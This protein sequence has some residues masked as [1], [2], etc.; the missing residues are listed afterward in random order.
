MNKAAADK[1]GLV[2]PV[3]G[4]QQRLMSLSVGLVLF[5]PIPFKDTAPA[6]KAMLD[7]YLQFVPR[8]QFRWQNLGGSSA[9]FKALAPRAFATTDAWLTFQRSY[10]RSCAIW[11][12]DGPTVTSVGD[13]L[14]NLWGKDRASRPCDS[15]YLR[16]HF[17]WSV[18]ETDAREGFLT[19][20]HAMLQD[21]PFHSGYLGYMLN[22]STLA[23]VVPYSDAINTAFYAA[24]RR[25]VGLE[26]TKPHLEN[27]E[28]KCFLRPPSWVT[29]VSAPFLEKLG[30]L[31]QLRGELKGTFTF[32][33]LSHGWSIQAGSEP[34][35]GDQNRQQDVAPEQRELARRFAPLYSDKPAYLF[36]DKPHLETVD[37]MRRL[38]K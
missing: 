31:E 16:L 22:V 34:R 7:S 3:G 38:T 27:Y 5:T 33:Q 4:D 11:L 21:V 12:K 2:M 36:A 37:W 6:F 18:A 23:T 8:T 25:Y 19:A 15:N 10:G 28:M 14:F 1:L 20:I 32:R 9:S 26:V 30:G 24:A 13:H 35:L 17:P 29:F